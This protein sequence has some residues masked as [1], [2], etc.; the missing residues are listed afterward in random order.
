MRTLFLIALLF[1]PV[2]AQ[3]P[4][5]PVSFALSVEPAEGKFNDTLW[6]EL[7]LNRNLIVASRKPEF[8]IYVVMTPLV[9]EGRQFGYA[10]AVLVVTNDKY[11]LSIHTGRGPEPLARHV[12]AVLEKDFFKPKR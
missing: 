8:D 10:A 4:L 11:H 9:D 5:K 7:R 1:I 2:T 6:H 12:A 3:A